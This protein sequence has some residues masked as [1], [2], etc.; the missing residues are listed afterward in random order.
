MP[1]V[2]DRSPIPA[3]RGGECRKCGFQFFPFQALGC[4]RCGASGEDLSETEFPAR[5]RVIS[6]ALVYLSSTKR[7]EAPYV[8]V[9]VQ[10]DG[11]PVVRGLLD[12]AQPPRS[13]SPVAARLQPEHE[14]SL[15]DALRFVVDEG[16]AV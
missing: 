1:L 13:G 5:G 15:D 11:G 9:E 2:I 4:E 14:G 8:A 10:L 12:T 7:V 6:S 3:L 16:V